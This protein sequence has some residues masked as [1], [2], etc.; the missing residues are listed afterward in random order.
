MSDTITIALAQIA[1]VWFDREKTL[2]KVGQNISEAAGT[3]ADLVAFG[4]T[5]VPGYPFWLEYSQV[6]AFNSSFHKRF[7]AEYLNQSICIERGDLNSVCK[8]ARE[9][10]I[11]VYL[12]VLERP[13][14]RGGKSVYASLVYIAK[15]GEIGSVHRKLMPTYDERMTWAT[16]DGNGLRTHELGPFTVGGLNCWENWMPLARTALYAQGEDLH[17]A[18]WPG[19]I[20]NTTDITRFIAFESRSFVVSVSGLMRKSDLPTHLPGIE[21]V[22]AN[23]PDYLA[24]GGSCIAGPDGK[25]IVEPFCGEEKII[26]ATLDHRRVR[27]ERQN[28]DA[29]GHYSRPDVLNLKVD[30]RRQTTA[31]FIDD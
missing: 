10:R 27:E 19:C 22:I 4:E 13:L 2:A 9:K 3:G 28:F 21:D 18:V 30:R 8:Q 5:V 23:S 14:D 12:G 24:D 17:V 25:W 1:P 15:D 29:A 6:P 7:H 26:I 20:R 16:G 31:E 11:A